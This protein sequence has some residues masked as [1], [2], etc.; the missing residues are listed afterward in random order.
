MVEV[1]RKPEIM[2]KAKSELA[3]VI[4]KGTI[5]EEADIARLANAPASSLFDSQGRSRPSI[6]ARNGQ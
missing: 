3:D 6:G 1:M 4:G 2:N 5:I